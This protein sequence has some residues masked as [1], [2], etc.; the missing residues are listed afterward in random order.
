ML[1]V[2]WGEGGVAAIVCES[3]QSTLVQQSRNMGWGGG[4]TLDGPLRKPCTAILLLKWHVCRANFARKIFIEPRISYEKYSEI[5][6]KLLSLSFVRKKK[7]PTQFPQFP[8]EKS[9]KN[10]QR[11]FAG[12]QGGPFVLLTGFPRL[13]SYPCF[14]V[15]F[16]HPALS[17]LFVQRMTQTPTTTSRKCMTIH[18]HRCLETIGTKTEEH[19]YRDFPQTSGNQLPQ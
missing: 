18:H 4:G 5:S 15:T 1:F 10:H 17:P 12:A 2:L 9:K 19:W 14:S 13:S 6:P 7:N 11:A 3:P 16:M 8:C